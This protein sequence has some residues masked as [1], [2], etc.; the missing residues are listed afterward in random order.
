M[1]TAPLLLHVTAAV[2][3]GSAPVGPTTFGIVIFVTEASMQGGPDESQ[4]G[5]DWALFVTITTIAHTKNMLY[6][7]TI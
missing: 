5:K 1:V 6:L 2:V 3:L 4:F 7:F